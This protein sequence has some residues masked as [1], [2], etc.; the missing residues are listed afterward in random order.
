MIEITTDMMAPWVMHSVKLEA[1]KLQIFINFERW[2]GR[3]GSKKWLKETMV[4][5]PKL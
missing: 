2:I 4:R 1:I 3:F 5:M